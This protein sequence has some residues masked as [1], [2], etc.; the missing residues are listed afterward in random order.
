MKKRIKH[1]LNF[2]LKEVIL[3]YLFCYILSVIALAVPLFL[4]I[5][6]PWNSWLISFSASIFSL[7]VI[8]I[9]YN[10]YV[11][12]LEKH[13]QDKIS[14][15]INNNVINVF[16][17]FIYFT[18][19]FYYKLEDKKDGDEATLNKIL[20][21]SEKELF[22]LISD[23]TFSG[24]ILFSEFDSFDTYIDDIINEPVV[25]KYANQEDISILIDF[26]NSYNA[27][28]DIFNS[29]V[30]NDYIVCGKYENIDIQ[31]SNYAKN[32]KGKIF[33]DAMWLL[34]SENVQSFYTAMYPIYEKE[35]LL[36]KLKLSGTKS[37]EIAD[38]IKSVY[39]CINKWLSIHSDS[40]ISISNSIV[41]Y[42]R[43]HLD[44]DI[45]FNQYMKK[46]LRYPKADLDSNKMGTVTLS[47]E[48]NRKKVPSR[49]RIEDGFSKESNK[50]VIR[51]LAEG[52]KW[53]NTPS[54]RRIQVHIHF[55]IGKNGES[56][57]A[58]LIVLPSGVKRKP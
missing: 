4:N 29:I 26:I 53:E 17:Q 57:K 18:E 41:M 12:A 37:Q 58:I 24:I 11:S 30:S 3:K 33:Y 55:T 43:L 25:C 34:D 45:T 14:Q 22:K 52:P 6:E 2:I 13:T 35:S 23:N 40:R 7:P 48:L 10:L 39:N 50:E 31:E 44:Y 51:L 38:S 54:G 46:A 32:N 8:F 19:Y 1:T 27:F 20:M 16:A 5:D 47:F 28:K 15:K 21:Y 56:H 36:L 49:I 9:I 42:G